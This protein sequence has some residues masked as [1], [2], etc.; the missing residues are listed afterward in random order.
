MR[1]SRVLAVGAVLTALALCG[2]VTASADPSGTPTYRDIAGVGSDTTQDV[3]NGLADSI[4]VGGTKVLGSY[5]A[6]G[7]A[8]ITTKD[9]AVNANCTLNRPSGSGAGVT[10]LVN[11]LDAGNGCLQ[12]ARSSSNN[13]GNYVGKNL[14]YVPFA[15]DGLTYAVRSDS[16][17]SK[18]LTLA[19]LTLIY[20][21]QG[22]ANYIPL[23]PQFGSGT[24]AFFLSKLQIADSATLVGSTGHT[25]LKDTD[26]N[27]QPI[28]ENTGTYLTDPK[29]VAPY[30]I[31]QY[32]SQAY[33]V[34]ADV[35][36]KAILASADG[37]APTS[38]NTSVPMNRNVYNVVP[39]AALGTA[40][41]NTIFTGTG[42]G[43]ICG[44]PDLIKK[45]GFAP[46]A[47]CGSTNLQTP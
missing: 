18:K 8:T 25:C 5:D 2:S 42:P 43:T 17:I 4:T 26:V 20:N 38:L 12:F 23:L 11:S 29:H 21:C 16:A 32:Q 7:S 34:I 36:A 6:S 47:T 33:G 22:G 24:R 9:P 40:P 35:R 15:V 10:A 27:G 28:L 46:N 44:S 45:Y 3:V 31:A 14:T 13:S 30:S 37:V 39:N 41:Y 19:Q 1:K